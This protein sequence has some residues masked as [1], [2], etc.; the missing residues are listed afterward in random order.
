MST[1]SFDETPSGGYPE[2]FASG[3]AA[4]IGGEL[5]GGD[6][7]EN[8]AELPANN[9]PESA[10][11]PAAQRFTEESPAEQAQA[12]Q[13]AEAAA[14]MRALPKSWKKDMEQYWK[15]LPPQVHDY[16]YARE[17]DVMRGLQQ[18]QEG[19]RQW[20][21]LL[22]PYGGVF[23][24]HPDVN[25]VQLMQNLMNTHLQL[26]NPSL[27][28]GQKLQMAQRIMA[29]YGIKLDGQPA[30]PADENSAIAALQRRLDHAE[31]LA[32]QA[33]ERLTARERAEYDAG[34]KEYEAKIE[35]FATD[36]KNKYFAEVEND[37]LRFV[38]SGAAS[39]L[40]AA[41]ELACYANPVVRA[42]LLAE[43]Q[44]PAAQS[45]STPASTNRDSRGRFVN[46]DGEPPQ[47]RT[48]RPGTIDQTID[49]IIAKAYNPQSNL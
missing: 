49:S 37:I 6:G 24:Q 22:K 1:N 29:S 26:L 17:A 2:D 12:T 15:T 45:A 18:Y 9:P 42:K 28:A 41:Y 5:F 31:Q 3:V 27:D 23:Q 13:A 14:A 47:R 38:Q 46:L 32:R 16:V 25:P 11:K 44:A 20:E 21:T 4:E 30:T 33:A 10:E 36:P 39:T 35:A 43:Q 48:A 40:E 7:G 8:T 34:V 19:H